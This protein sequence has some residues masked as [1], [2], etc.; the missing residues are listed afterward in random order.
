MIDER[1]AIFAALLN[2]VAC[3][4]YLIATVKGQTKPNKVSWFLWAA[5][6]FIA[7]FAQIQQGVGLSAVYTFSNGFGPL[8]VFIG[9]FFNKQSEW[10]ITKFDLICGFLSLGGVFFWYLTRVGN[11]AITCS[12]FADWLASVPTIVKAYKAPETENG[13]AF[14]LGTVAAFIAIFTVTK[15]DFASYAFPISAT[16][17]NF[18]IFVLVS[19]KVGKLIHITFAKLY[20]K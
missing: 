3:S 18:T 7:F 12:I 9:S 8:L 4:I 14:L 10:K 11:I 2:L 17:I 1:F 16:L 15:W 20:R 19:L 5:V 13:R 6:P